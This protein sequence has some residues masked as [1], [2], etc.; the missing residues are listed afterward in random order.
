VGECEEPG[1]RHTT[2]D[3]I[4]RKETGDK[5]KV[6]WV[7]RRGPQAHSPK[8]RQRPQQLR[9]QLTRQR[10]QVVPQQLQGNRAAGEQGRGVG[11]GGQGCRALVGGDSS[12]GGVWHWVGVKQR[13]RR[14]QQS[15]RNKVAWALGGH[16]TKTSATVWPIRCW[17]WTCRCCPPHLEHCVQQPLGR[18][19]LH[20]RKRPQHLG[21][22]AA[23]GR[24][25]RGASSRGGK[26]AAGM[27]N[28][29][30]SCV[31]GRMGR[32]VLIMIQWASGEEGVMRSAVVDACS[33]Q[34]IPRCA[35]KHT[36]LIVTTHWQALMHNVHHP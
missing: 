32:G 13:S 9:Q 4:G 31:V 12:K 28:R 14:G 34:H 30:E 25:G 2:T 36:W 5:D 20:A 26:P 3:G 27:T 22:P 16:K 15:R 10:G 7:H 23:R 33:R 18:A 17:A 21:Q 35:D 11:G 8:L 19:V 6:G 24:Q 1:Q 29:A